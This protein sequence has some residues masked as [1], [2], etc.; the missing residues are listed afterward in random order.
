MGNCLASLVISTFQRPHLL[1]WGL[2]SIARQQIPFEYEIIVVN[3]GVMDET[4]KICAEY[5]HRLNVRYIFSGQR[6]LGGTLNWRVPGFAINI[7]ARQAT[8][9]VLLI[10]CA[11]I[12]HLNSTLA[13][14]VSPILSNNTL[15]TIPAGKDDR[16]GAF[17]N[18][19]ISSSGGYDPRLYDTLPDLN[20]R[21]PFLLALDRVHFNAIRGYDEDFTGIAFDDDDLVGRLLAYGLRYHQTS[22][23]IV[24]LYHPRYVYETGMNAAWH[25]NR[26]LYLTRQGVLVR[27]TTREWGKL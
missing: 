21:L 24:H 23:R 9:R 7:G 4:E 11:E 26:N 22:A 19:V 1:K 25:Y 3:D 18:S 17:L 6:N 20:V 5:S 12:Y 27:N 13:A 15:M 2:E 8:G 14:L 16:S 10:S